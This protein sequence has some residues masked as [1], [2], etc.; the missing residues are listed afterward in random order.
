MSPTRRRRRKSDHKR[1]WVV[2]SIH[3]RQITEQVSH[4]SGHCPQILKN[5]VRGKPPHERTP[6]KTRNHRLRPLAEPIRK[7][8]ERG[9]PQIQRGL[10]RSTCSPGQART[11]EGCV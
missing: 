7:G 3:R 1:R 5:N 4:A 2:A 11:R 6:R 10:R 8:R 9:K